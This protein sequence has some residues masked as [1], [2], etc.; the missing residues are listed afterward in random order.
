MSYFFI[1]KFVSPKY[2]FC[3]ADADADVDVDVD[4][5]ADAEMPMPS[6]PNCLFSALMKLYC[7]V[8]Y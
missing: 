1:K 8:F 2:N 7:L 6:F 5:N 4:V 3:N